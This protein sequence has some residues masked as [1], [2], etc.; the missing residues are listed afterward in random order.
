MLT[1]RQILHNQLHP[2]RGCSPDRSAGWRRKWS[3]QFGFHWRF[4]Q[5]FRAPKTEEA[6]YSL[7]TIEKA[8]D[9]P[10]TI[11]IIDG[12]PYWLKTIKRM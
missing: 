5:S 3:L 9:G 1:W 2:Y 11:E 4:D 6:K 10:I 12:K 7:K 8:S